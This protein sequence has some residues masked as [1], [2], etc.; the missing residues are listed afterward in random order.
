MSEEDRA[1]MIDGMV[2]GLATRL[3]EDPS[4]AA[5]W[6]RLAR[7]YQ[8]MGRTDEAQTALIGAADARSA[9]AATQIAALEH[10]VVN[11]LEQAFAP[12]ASRL[13]GRL[14]EIAPDRPET[15]YIRGHFARINGD[16]ATARQ[17][18]QALLDRMPSDA[19]IADQLRAAI[20]AL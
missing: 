8:V 14:A 12:A 16:A 18:W 2:E 15:M 9:D 5:G 3:A 7:A 19:P 10:M 6:Q 13:L 17:L 4:D 20:D 11:Q 1:A